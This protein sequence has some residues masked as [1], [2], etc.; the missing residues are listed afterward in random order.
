MVLGV[1]LP[2]GRRGFDHGTADASVVLLGWIIDVFCPG[3][4]HR[5]GPLQRLSCCAAVLFRVPLDPLRP[6]STCSDVLALDAGIAS[7]GDAAHT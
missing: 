4:F 1:L 5:I 7:G 6:C 2:A 3:S